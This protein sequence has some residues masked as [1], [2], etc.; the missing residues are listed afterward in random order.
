M[1]NQLP[2]T[3]G[4]HHVALKAAGLESFQ[5]MIRFYHELLG[6]PIVRTWGE[7]DSSAAML[8]TGDGAVLELFAN[9]PDVL[10]AGALRHIAFACDDPDAAIERVRREGYTVTME[11]KDIV[12]PSCPP[13]P[14][15]IAFCI[16]PVGEEVEFFC[17]KE[18]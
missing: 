13:Y 7:G 9:A 14:A 17:V 12:I 5:K 15:R 3:K 1:M 18:Q 16:G 6:M 4:I 10:G 11:P 8:D 2:R